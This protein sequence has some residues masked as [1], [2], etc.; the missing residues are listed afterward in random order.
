M[1]SLSP[2]TLK[3]SEISNTKISIVIV[4]IV[5]IKSARS[6]YVSFRAK[7]MLIHQT[8]KWVYCQSQ[9]SLPIMLADN[10]L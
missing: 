5:A 6:M 10:Y 2:K 7:P 8:V 4:A 9:S 3:F 1:S